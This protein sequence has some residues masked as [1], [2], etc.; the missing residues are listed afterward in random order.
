MKAGLKRT[1]SWSLVV[2]V[3]CMSSPAKAD[4]E[5]L[6]PRNQG[7]WDHTNSPMRT[8]RQ[9]CHPGKIICQL[10]RRA[11]TK[12]ESDLNDRREYG[13]QLG[14]PSPQLPPFEDAL[15]G[16]NI[17]AESDLNESSVSGP[18]IKEQR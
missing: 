14:T 9:N 16:P 12:K 10:P 17:G 4:D 8:Y 3:L 15:S 18:A 11:L 13:D 5:A 7:D 6:N 1:A 2:I